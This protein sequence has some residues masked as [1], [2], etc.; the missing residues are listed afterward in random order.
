ME[1]R[2]RKILQDNFAGIRID[3]EQIPGQKIAGSVVWDGFAGLD[4]VDRQHLVRQ[5]LQAA[6]GPE[7]QQVGILL[8]YTPEELGAMLAA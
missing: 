4:H 8:T 1:Q 3:L 5:A 6:L 2:V 7:I